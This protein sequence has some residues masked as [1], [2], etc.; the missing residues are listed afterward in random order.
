MSIKSKSIHIYVCTCDEC[1]KCIEVQENDKI[2]NGAQ[3]ARSLGWKFG[4]D[5]S[6]KCDKCRSNDWNDHYN[7]YQSIS[8]SK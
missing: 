8:V 3:A 4:K 1:G 5:R 2:Y 6:V 7:W